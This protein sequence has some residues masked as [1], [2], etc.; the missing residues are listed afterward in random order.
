METQIIVIELDEE[1]VI[2]SCQTPAEIGMILV[3]AYCINCESYRP[4]WKLPCNCNNGKNGNDKDGFRL[5]EKCEGRGYLNA[6]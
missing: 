5:C 4:Q 3:N 2:C 6:K 1:A